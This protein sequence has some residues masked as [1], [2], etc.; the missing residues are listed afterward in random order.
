MPDNIAA[1]SIKVDDIEEK[2]L[3]VIRNHC[4]SDAKS[5][6]SLS[7]TLES[8][9]IDSL[10]MAEAAFDLEDIFSFELPE[11]KSSEGQFKTVRDIYDAIKK[12]ISEKS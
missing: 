11:S 1:N 3:S 4:L 5:S 12:H 7:S 6:I 10:G 9:G 2:L 8:T